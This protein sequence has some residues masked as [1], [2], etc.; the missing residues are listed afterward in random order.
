[1]H[2]FSPGYVNDE[3]RGAECWN[4]RG[5]QRQTLCVCCLI[6]I[7][8]FLNKF[9]FSSPSPCTFS[10][11]C[12]SQKPPDEIS[13]SFLFHVSQFP[14][15]FLFP[16]YFLHYLR[17]ADKYQ[18]ALSPSLW[19]PTAHPL[20]LNP[21]V[22]WGHSS[23]LTSHTSFGGIFTCLPLLIKQQEH[24]VSSIL[25]GQHGAISV[26]CQECLQRQPWVP[27]TAGSFLLQWRKALPRKQNIPHAARLWES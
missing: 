5:A 25:E 18:T 21:W 16:F 17:E 19:A 13:P 20:L 27:H 24:K 7:P 12:S 4:P 1:M 9:M 6:P 14:L 11:Y 10:V 15:H 26:S 23:D 8:L 3:Q 2:L 22:L